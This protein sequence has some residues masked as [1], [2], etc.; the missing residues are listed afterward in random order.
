[1]PLFTVDC[2]DYV[3]VSE[4]GEEIHPRED[5]WV[6]FKQRTPA[7]L[8]KVMLDF[9]GLQ[10]DSGSGEDMVAELGGAMDSLL[11]LLVKHIHS[12]N[13]T[14]VWEDDRPPLG[15]PAEE[16]LWDLDFNELTYLVEKLLG[17][18]EAKKETNS[19]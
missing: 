12:W 17:G 15:E 14:D 6:K 3:I 7:R 10:Q 19:P 2:G 13:W 11:P 8:F 1:M 9:V 16:V 4:D 18:V 5:E